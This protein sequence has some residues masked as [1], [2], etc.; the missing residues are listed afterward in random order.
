MKMPRLSVEAESHRPTPAESEIVD[1]LLEATRN[2][3]VN[4][5]PAGAAYAAEAGGFRFALDEQAA[6]VVSDSD[7][8]L[9]RLKPAMR[10]ERFAADDLEDWLDDIPSWEASLAELLERVQAD[11]ARQEQAR[12]G[13][14]LSAALA[15]LRSLE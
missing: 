7:G 10:P 4:W 1:R 15:A 12:R 13:Q 5:V 2:Q 6:L 9:A 3:R 11:A 8:E 14:R